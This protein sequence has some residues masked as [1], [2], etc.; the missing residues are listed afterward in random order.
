M[1]IF[2]F[3]LIVG[4]FWHFSVDWVFVLILRFIACFFPPCLSFLEVCLIIFM[5]K[6]F[7]MLVEMFIIFGKL[8]K[9]YIRLLTKGIL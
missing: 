7:F 2:L 5:N 3:F 8:M 4:G 6:E 9:K 1:Y